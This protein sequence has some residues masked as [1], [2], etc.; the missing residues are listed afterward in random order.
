MTIVYCGP[1]S[2]VYV[3]VSQFDIHLCL[4]ITHLTFSSIDYLNAHR[5]LRQ[6]V[7]R[8]G[9]GTSIIRETVFGASKPRGQAM[10]TQSSALSLGGVS[11]NYRATMTSKSQHL[12]YSLCRARSLYFSPLLW[13]EK[14][15][16]IYLGRGASVVGFL[17]VLSSV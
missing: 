15:V 8:E 17:K 5:R 16:R 7:K 12:F 14:N 6:D 13:Q 9:N 10:L 2:W 11:L 1:E 4:R 3:C